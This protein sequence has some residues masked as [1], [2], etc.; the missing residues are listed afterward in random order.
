MYSDLRQN[1]VPID[2]PYTPSHHKSTNCRSLINSSSSTFTFLHWMFMVSLLRKEL[3]ISHIYF[4][5]CCESVLI[6]GPPLN[7][8]EGG[9][10]CSPSTRIL[11][12][13]ACMF[14]VSLYI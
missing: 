10:G 1:G 6:F 4:M 13:L 12:T 14:T 3:R 9:R 5:T 8:G 7:I 11:C 2:A